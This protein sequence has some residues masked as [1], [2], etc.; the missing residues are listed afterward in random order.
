MQ[1]AGIVPTLEDKV[2]QRVVLMVLEPVYEQDSLDCSYGF[3]PGRS[4]HQAL[5]ALWR[6]LM[7]IGGGWVIDLDIQ[8]FLDRSS[9]CPQAD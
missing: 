5:E 4:P 9:Y 8:S 2:L 7:G 1:L 6:G 3:Q